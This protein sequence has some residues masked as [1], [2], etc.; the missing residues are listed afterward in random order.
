MSVSWTSWWKFSV[1]PN[2]EMVDVTVL[3]VREDDFG[4]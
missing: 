4:F 1:G 2:W 3:D